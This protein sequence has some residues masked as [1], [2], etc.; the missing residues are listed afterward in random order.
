MSTTYITFNF[1][2]GGIA[3]DATSA[4]LEDP[5]GAFGV[6][7]LDTGGVVVAAGTAFTHASTGRYTYNFTDPAYGLLYEVW[8]KW[9]YL[10]NTYF[11]QSFVYG[12]VAPAGGL[13]TSS[14]TLVQARSMVRL[15]ARNAQDP[16]FY[17][18]QQI[19]FALQASAD[20]I[21]RDCALL[22]N[23]S[24][25]T[26]AA[27]T[28]TLGAMPSGFRADRITSSYLTGSNVVVNPGGILAW[29]YQYDSLGAPLFWNCPPNTAG[30]ALVDFNSLN[31]ATLATQ[32]VG[33]PV[34]VAF[35]AQTGTGLCFPT[36]DTANSYQWNFTWN[37]LFTS[38]QAGLQGVYAA[39]TSYRLGDIVANDN[40]AS[41]YVF[42]QSLANANLAHTPLS[43]PTYWSPVG[44]GSLT[45]P[46]AQLFNLPDEYMRK[47][48]QIGAPLQLIATSPE[49]QRI[50]AGLETK[51]EAFKLSIQG[52]GTFGAQVVVSASRDD[53]GGLGGGGFG[54]G[55]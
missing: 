9:V 40:T 19:D 5:T 53:G 41:A 20:E 39:G 42:Y 48:C 44:T 31:D 18:D 55:W 46:A 33:Q 32:S 10:G 43:S 24:S 16:S 15:F 13:V 23:T 47:L 2:V 21:V 6:K 27:G 38:W 49:N 11:E 28:N 34:A 17:T 25:M 22:L 3:T 7:R 30:I 1:F 54:G 8:K 14:I 36:P 29:G 37:N 26:L 35:D 12:T 51:W 4:V 52:K 50:I 45:L